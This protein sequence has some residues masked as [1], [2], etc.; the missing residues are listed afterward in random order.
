MKYRRLGRSG[1]NVSEICLGTHSYG[2]TTEEA[3]AF[4]VMDAF[5]KAG[6]NFIDT[7][8]MY[9]NWHPGNSGGESETIIGRWLSDRGNRR[10]VVLATKVKARLWDGPNGEGLSRGHIMQACDDSLR[11]LQT[12]YIDLYQIHSD[13]PDTPTEETLVALNDL[14]RAG[15]VRYIG[16][17]NL[18]AWRLAL[19]LGVS[20]QF[21]LARYVSC[22]PY[23]N[24]LDRADVERELEAC[25][26]DQGVG[27]IPY[28]PL[29]GGFL[30]GKYQ[31]DKSLPESDRA[32]GIESRYFNK[33]GW[34]VLEALNAVA[35]QHEVH[36]SQIALA[37]LL[38]RPAMV[39]PINGCR[40]VDQ[41]E[42]NI[43]AIDV[44][45]DDKQ[46]ACLES[47]SDPEQWTAD[48]A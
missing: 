3:A 41:L 21:G 11:R 7:A 8:D 48:P 42:A 35:Q 30:S 25:C 12:D 31:R 26:V 18:T 28:S 14:V 45:L 9:S 44:I 13:D 10:P 22:Q 16:C 40:S 27:I 37:W 38:T 32:E 6:G 47:A 4:E 17:S 20:D 46:I 39:A 24:L 34:A 36:P 15:K 19:S 23:Y 2:E 5:V 43:G 29:A 1:L 33:R